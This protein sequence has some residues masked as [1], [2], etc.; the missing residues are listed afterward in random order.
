MKHK[1]FLVLIIGLLL[2]LSTAYAATVSHSASQVLPGSF[3]VG[4]YYFPN[5]NVGIGTT[6][7]DGILT[8]EKAALLDVNLRTT[9]DDLVRFRVL[10]NNGATEIRL[11]AGRS[12][13]AG[14]I[15]ANTT[16]IQTF[17][18]TD[19]DFM[20]NNTARMTIDSTGNVGIGTTSPGALLEVK[21]G[22]KVDIFK[23][24]DTTSNYFKFR[25]SNYDRTILGGYHTDSTETIRFD[26]DPASAN[27]ILG[28]VGIGTTD[29]GVKLHIKANAYPMQQFKL[30]AASGS[31]AI[32]FWQNTVPNLAIG[33]KDYS[34]A[35]KVY[36]R[37][38]GNSYFNGGNVG[39]GTTSPNVALDVIGSIEY[40]GTITDV[41]DIRLK[42]NFVP[43]INSLSMIQGMK[44]YTF[45]M[46]DDETRQAGVIAQDVQKVL[47]EAVSVV[48]EENGYLGVDYTQLVPVLIEAVKELKSE[49]N[50][51][52]EQ[53]DVLMARVEALEN[54]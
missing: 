18:D 51:K 45:N 3:Q 14:A 5:G 50:A 42:E 20:T 49:N 54:K 35:G 40:T 29:P 38:D 48:D 8:I 41:S 6:S 23:T 39:I 47:P 27:W 17:T 34:G 36:I 7:P 53:I 9:S 2:S 21:G 46:I 31:G 16:A 15:R 19:M 24:A 22:H 10:G 4:S 43:I 1:T 25:N 28:N 12:T 32:Y 30:S 33:I 37:P 11:I 26:T 13:D 44:G 52:Q